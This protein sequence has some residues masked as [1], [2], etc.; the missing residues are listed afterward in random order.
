M[1]HSLRQNL[2]IKR[3]ICLSLLTLNPLFTIVSKAS[4]LTNSD[5]AKGEKLFHQ[6]RSCHQ[7]HETYNGVG[8]YL[9]NIVGRKAG[10]V[11]SFVY[12][13][14]VANSGI[15]WTNENLDAFLKDP[16]AFIPG[17]KMPFAGIKSAQDRQN[18]IS[19]LNSLSQ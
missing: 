19:Y 17:N 11:N 2:Y 3:L 13:K 1:N 7:G 9:V 5:I 10:S 14:A 12:S 6:C 15:T 18:L 16:A 8:P 4:E